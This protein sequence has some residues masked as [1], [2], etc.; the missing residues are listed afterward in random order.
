MNDPCSITRRHALT[1]LASSFAPTMALAAPGDGL[2]ASAR[3]WLGQRPKL[4]LVGVLDISRSPSQQDAAEVYLRALTQFFSQARAGDE[5]LA[6]T[7]GDAGIDRVQMKGVSLHATGKTF[8]D[9]HT[10][11][12]GVDSVSAWLKGP[13]GGKLQSRYLET[14]AA[15]QPA[16]L[17]VLRQGIPVQVLVAGDGVENSPMAN[18]ER[19][20]DGK[21]L[22]ENLKKK[23]LILGAADATPQSGQQAKLRLMFVGA[24]G[25]NEATFTRCRDFWQAY[26][27]AAHTELAYYG[28]DLPPFFA[29]GA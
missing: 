18:F 3:Q 13:P 20:F 21:K 28:R 6:T 29:S 5:L 25:S 4:L 1:C 11:K 8:Q 14:F 17:N 19:P 26:A 24:G 2:L 22:L 10:L 15:L 12:Q 16:V 23:G 27:T 7:V 9:N